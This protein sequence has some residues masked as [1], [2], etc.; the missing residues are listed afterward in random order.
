MRLQRLRQSP[1]CGKANTTQNNT[2]PKLHS[3]FVFKTHFLNFRFR[4][5]VN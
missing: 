4:E 3:F 2:H 5:F 1:P